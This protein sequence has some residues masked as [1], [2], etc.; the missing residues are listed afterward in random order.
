MI[1]SVLSFFQNR[2]K[3]SFLII[4]GVKCA[5]SSLFRYL[6]D[7]P[8]ILPG[9][10]KESGFFNHRGYSKALVTLPRYLSKFPKRNSNQRAEMI[11]PELNEA[12]E[13]YNVSI[14]TERHAHQSYMTG[15]ATATY[16]FSANPKVIKKI[17]PDIKIIF[18][19]R[20]PTSR[21]ISH[22]DMFNRFE[23]E[24]RQGYSTG[25]LVSFINKEIELYKE[26][27]PTRI[28]HQGLYHHYLSNWESE[29]GS[30]NIFVGHSND[31]AHPNTATN[32]LNKLTSFLNL[33]PHDFTTII[34]RKFNVSPQR[35]LNEEAVSLLDEFYLESNRLVKNH[36]HIDLY[37]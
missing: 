23:K 29:F 3:P 4:G 17:F 7:H 31:L 10:K 21:F 26:K 8:S 27:K 25:E 37:E 33:L 9:E 11:W 16:N 12:G 36:Y 14:Q 2:M 18:L 20:N 28:L 34:N 13:V 19:L 1:A 5:S 32:M 22:F 24:G 6:V 35:T 30:K 15:E